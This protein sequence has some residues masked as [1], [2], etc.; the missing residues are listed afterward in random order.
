LV[1]VSV[2]SSKILTKIQSV[3]K[4]VKP[5]KRHIELWGPPHSNT[6]FQVLRSLEVLK[7]S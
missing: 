5:V 2:H 7:G 3:V 1:M 4:S 6:E